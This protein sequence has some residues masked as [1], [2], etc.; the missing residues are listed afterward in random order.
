M[1]SRSGFVSNSSSSSFVVLGV[2]AQINAQEAKRILRR[3]FGFTKDSLEEYED[4]SE[5]MDALYEAF[6][7]EEKY[8]FSSEPPFIGVMLGSSDDSD[9][10]DSFSYDLVELSHMAQEFAVKFG[11]NVSEVKLI[12]GQMSC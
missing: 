12:G 8:V 6:E 10:L 9:M 7:E 3:V 11:Y 1:K 2:D 4:D 5:V